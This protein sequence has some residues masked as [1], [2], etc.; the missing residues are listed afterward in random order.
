MG[1]EVRLPMTD[2]AAHAA[3][4][5]P[6]H[7][8]TTETHAEPGHPTADEHDDHGHATEALGPVDVSAWGAGVV[9]VAVALVV[10][11]C[12]AWTTGAL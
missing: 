2:P 5:G 4:P 12:F 8:T 10:A 1:A 3:P 6:P 11:V 7:D 9:G